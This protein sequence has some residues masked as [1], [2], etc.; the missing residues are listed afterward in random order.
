MTQWI[1]LFRT[2]RTWLLSVFLLSALSLASQN[3]EKISGNKMEAKAPNI[4]LIMADDMGFSDIGCYGSEIH[5]PHIDQLAGQGIRFTRMYNNAWC[6]P[7]RASLLTG[8]YPLQVGLGVLAGPKPGPEGP[9][10]GYLNRDCVTLAEV[11]KQA[12]YRTILSGKWHLGE[13]KPNWPT[14]RGFDYYFGLIS[15]A[16]NYFDITKTKDNSVVRYMALDDQPYT[17]PKEGF[18]MTDAITDYAVKMLE[19]QM[20]RKDPFF[21]Y[22]AYTAPHWPLQALPEDIVK[23]KDQYDIG[24]DSLRVRRYNKQIRLGILEKNT[25]LSARDPE[26]EAWKELSY[27]RKKEMAEKMTVYAAQIDRM[28]QGIG[29]ILDKLNAIGKNN[30][31]IVIFLSDNGACAE[32]GIWGFDWRNNSLPPGGEDSYMSYGQSWANAGN[33][34]FRFFKKWLYEGGISTP[35]IIKWPAQ[36]TKKRAGKIVDQ[37]AHL[38]DIM[39]TICEL[40][41]AGYPERYNGRRIL[42]MEGQSLAPL[43]TRGQAIPHNPVYWSL[44]GHKAI[45]MGDYKLEAVA[46]K[47][48]WELYDLRKD[49]SELNDLAKTRPDK[50]KMMSEM[51]EQWADKVGVSKGRPKKRMSRSKGFL[52]EFYYNA[53]KS[54]DM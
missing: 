13:Y 22:V 34:P 42:P 24:W 5:T 41:G 7:S 2:R 46:D 36:I 33:T 10:Q 15:G 19:D 35:L 54:Q 37:V 8:L 17:P 40:A 20:S 18:Y 47:A 6:S 39:P 23:Y 50:V 9:Y 16:A 3:G 32:T 31:T 1:L 52:P 25:K 44:N 30:N 45:L 29:R 12:G 49:R 27:A 28:D 4:L 51:W 38:T 53:G 11:L 43:I 21:L 14:D 26:S 48:P